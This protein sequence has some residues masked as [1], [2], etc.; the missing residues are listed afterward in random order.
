MS[1]IT[2]QVERALSY[3]NL[4]Y[5]DGERVNVTLGGTAQWRLFHAQQF[6]SCPQF[7]Y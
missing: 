1:C 3:K 2:S 7:T 4:M 6:W 5:N